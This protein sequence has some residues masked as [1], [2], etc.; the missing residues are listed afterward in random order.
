[1]EGRLKEKTRDFKEIP[2]TK[3][4][5]EKIKTY[6]KISGADECYGFLLTPLEKFDGV[7]YNAILAPDQRVSM[8]SAGISGEA[9]AYAKAE[10]KNLGYKPI[11]FW[12]SHGSMS[13]FHSGTDNKNMENLLLSLASNVEEKYFGDRK[14]GYDVEGNDLVFRRGSLEVKLSLVDGDFSFDVKPVQEDYFQTIAECNSKPQLVI[15][16]NQMVVI[17]DNGKR[18]MVKNPCSIQLRQ[19]TG[20]TIRNLGVAYSIVVNRRGEHYAQIGISKWCN[21]CER[22]ETEVSEAKLNVLDPEQDISFT[23]R[24]LETEFGLKVN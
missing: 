12:H 6:A 21:S 4:A 22:L 20:K 13:P 14:E 8:G 19:N 1:M 11:G 3:G 17:N 10:I 9:A 16:Q 5:F 23:K 2:I 18:L 7:I 15:T 24:E